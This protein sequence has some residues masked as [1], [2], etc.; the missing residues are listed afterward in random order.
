MLVNR[1]PRQARFTILSDSCHSGGLIN[2]EKEQ[3]GPH[4]TLERNGLPQARPK[5]IPP[6]SI[7]QHLAS[8]TNIDAS[9]V[10]THL[11]AHFGVDVIAKFRLS[12]RILLSGYQADEMSMDMLGSG[13]WSAYGAF[14]NA[15]EIVFKRHPRALTN[16]QVVTM[17]R[18]LLKEQGVG[19]HPFLYCTDE[20]IDAHFHRRP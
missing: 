1:V 16:K 8:I 15:V 7:L 11:V 19:R 9:D 17:A 2:K 18:R 4:T 20:N 6:E 3:T 14:S 5:F 10:E 12:A 13:G